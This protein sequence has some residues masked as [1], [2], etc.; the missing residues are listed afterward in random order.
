MFIN[1]VG[2]IQERFKERKFLIDLFLYNPD[3]E[4]YDKDKRYEED[5]IMF[6]SPLKTHYDDAEYGYVREGK[7]IKIPKGKPFTGAPFSL[8]ERITMNKGEASNYFEDEEIT[9]TIGR[10]LINYLLIAAPSNNKIPYMNIVFNG[11][12]DI[13]TEYAKLLLSLKLEVPQYR[14]YMDHGYFLSHFGELVVPSLTAKAL[15]T[16]PKV[17]KLKRELL[18]KHAD[19]LEDPMVIAA[20]EQQ[21][22]A[23][24][25]DWI[26]GDP[27]E[28]LFAPTAGKSYGVHRKKMFIMVGGVDDFSDKGGTVTIDHSLNDGWDKK[29]FVALANEVRNGSYARGKE[30]AKGGEMTK[31]IF[32]AFQDIKITEDD[33]ETKKGLKVSFGDLINPEQ[34]IGHMIIKGNV[35][36]EITHENASSFIGR[37]VT[38]RSPLFCTVKG[39][40]CYACAGMNFKRLGIEKPGVYAIEVSSKFMG[41]AM[42]SMHGTV[43]KTKEINPM[44]FFVSGE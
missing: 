38:V 34:F 44:D 36:E 31:F 9:T 18:L 30:T 29:N 37:T 25:K 8:T 1:Y 10:F 35:I 19:E 6:S 33:C 12:N 14:L 43:I 4:I 40:L 13:E 28:G 22:I 24:D 26:K 20:I 16:D 2:K 41:S 15:T 11:A 27:S 23:I 21:L 5:E 32:R 7:F 3:R 17:A 39:G 42:S